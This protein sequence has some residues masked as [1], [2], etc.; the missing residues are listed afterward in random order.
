MNRGI[1][2]ACTGVIREN[3]IAETASRIHS[4]SGGVRASH[5]LEDNA[6]GG[7][8]AIMNRRTIIVG[9]PS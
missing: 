6:D 3:P 5:A 8:G 7:L 1:V 9:D 4:D 2:E